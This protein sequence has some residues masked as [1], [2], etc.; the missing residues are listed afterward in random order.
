MIVKSGLDKFYNAN[1]NVEK[2]AEIEDNDERTCFT[3]FADIGL[4][5]TTTGANIFGAI[6][7][8]AD[9]GIN[10]PM[11]PNRLASGYYDKKTE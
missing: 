9:A 11:T 1:T 5:R 3:C 4:N 8:C 2:V 10:I 6:K 7:G